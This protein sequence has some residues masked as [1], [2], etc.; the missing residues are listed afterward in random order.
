MAN[1][2]YMTNETVATITQNS[3][4]LYSDLLQEYFLEFPLWDETAGMLQ[5]LPP[6]SSLG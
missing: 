3:P 1:T 2:Q 6:F 5:H 4:N